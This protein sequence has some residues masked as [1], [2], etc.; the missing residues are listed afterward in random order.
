MALQQVHY[1]YRM[2]LWLAQWESAQAAL[3]FA[4]NNRAEGVQPQYSKQL[5]TE[6]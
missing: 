4:I 2:R 6:H 3:I 5:L 1:S